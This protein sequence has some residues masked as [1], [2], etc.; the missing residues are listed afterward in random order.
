VATAVRQ[1]TCEA[2]GSNRTGF[3]RMVL[4]SFLYS[5]WPYKFR[6]IAVQ[7]LFPFGEREDF[8]LKFLRGSS[9]QELSW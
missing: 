7:K 6:A 2:I 8:R 3:I 1:R 9:K 5:L 4:V